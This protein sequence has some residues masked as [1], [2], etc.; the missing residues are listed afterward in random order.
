MSDEH[1]AA[2]VLSDL[3]RLRFQNALLRLQLG[4]SQAQQAQLDANTMIQSFQVPGWT[5]DVMT[6]SYTPASTPAEKVP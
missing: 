4:Q 1:G 3:Q 6:M 5:F 2:P